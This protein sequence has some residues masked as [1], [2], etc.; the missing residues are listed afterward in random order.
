MAD[1]IEKAE[2]Q[3]VQVTFMPKDGGPWFPAERLENVEIKG[4]R[5]RA[6]IDYPGASV[7]DVF[8]IEILVGILANEEQLEKVSDL[9]DLFNRDEET[10]PNSLTWTKAL[11]HLA[12]E[13]ADTMLR[14]RTA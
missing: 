3:L 10:D 5:V 6:P 8:A 12:Y 1:E 7:R 14:E 4:N 11:S 9:A 13:I 2:Q